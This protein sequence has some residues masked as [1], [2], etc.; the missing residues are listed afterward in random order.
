MRFEIEGSHAL[1]TGG[2]RGIGAAT[3]R[4]LVEKGASVTIIDVDAEELARR[5]DELRRLAAPRGA[6]VA[7][8]V[9]DI[10][11]GDA[12]TE[13]VRAIQREHGPVTILVN[14]AGILFPGDFLDQP[15]FKWEKLVEVNLTALIRLTHLLLPAMLAQDR[16]VV[17][18]LSSA[19]GAV[20]VAGLS[21]YAAT[22]WA[23]W[24]FSESLRH[25]V[26][27]GDNRGVHIASVHPNFLKSGLFEG[28]RLPR[29]G[30]LIVPRVKDH[31]VVARA[32]VEDAIARRKNVVMRPKSVRLAPFL[33]GVLPDTLFQRLTRSLGV[34]QSME[35]WRGR[36]DDDRAATPR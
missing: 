4:R 5:E 33:R 29:L 2:A 26:W 18:N 16:G 8:R 3:A 35:G 31:D 14:N 6:F 27:N 36:A 19:G 28:A 15:M 32:I 11:D 1:I 17:V 25:E 22:K 10:T 24:G 20:G 34:A 30:G 7:S 13:A 9:C 12:T 21:V 23:V